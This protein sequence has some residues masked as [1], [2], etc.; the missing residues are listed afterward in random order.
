MRSFLR[1]AAIVAV[2]GLAYYLVRGGVADR[3]DEAFHRARDILALERSLLLDWETA[4]HEAILHSDA[5]IE[6]ANV[7]YFWGHM[8][9]LIALAVGL[10]WRHRPIWQKLRNALVIS[11]AVGLVCYF[12][13][14][15]AP[16]RLMPELGYIDTLELRAAP[17]YQ[18]Q[19]M[20]IFVNPY[21]ALPSLHVGWA[22][23]AGLAVWQ[24]SRH[25]AM[26]AIAVL[27]PLAQCWAVVATANHWTLD[28]FAGLVVCA[29]AWLLALQLHKLQLSKSDEGGPDADRDNPDRAQPR[30]RRGVRPRLGQLSALAQRGAR[31][32]GRHQEPLRR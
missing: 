20:G 9:L 14:P 26:R 12:L 28:A 17:A 2:G 19:E 31:H 30:D 32:L 16:P 22:L 15:T 27:I 21:A 11:A 29:A 10:V 18:A 24:A 25:P 23:L 3:A 13:F 4:I 7:V 1:E 5:L 6:L 8:P